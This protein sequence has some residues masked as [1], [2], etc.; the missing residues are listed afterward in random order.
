[1]VIVSRNGRVNR[2]SRIGGNPHQESASAISPPMAPD[3][4]LRRIH[5]DT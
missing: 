1:M 4:R 5:R 2:F 3:V